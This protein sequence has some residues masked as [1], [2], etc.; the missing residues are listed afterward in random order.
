MKSSL[1]LLSLVLHA[2][3][4]E[5]PKPVRIGSGVS[6]HIHPA[7]C[8]TKNGTVIVIY[9]Q[10]DYRDHRLARS[11]DGYT[12]GSIPL[13]VL[14]AV[15]FAPSQRLRCDAAEALTRLNGVPKLY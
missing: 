12:N 2:V 15:S 13:K 14:C 10:A 3:P 7:A 6:G 11:T 5:L 8:V 4:A 9:C 1:L